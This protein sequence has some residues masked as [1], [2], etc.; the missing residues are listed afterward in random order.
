M[1]NLKTILRDA[2]EKY[3]EK[4]AIASGDFRISYEKL[5]ENSNKIAN[6]LL[7]LGVSRGDRVAILLNNSPHFVDIFFGIVKICAIAVPLD[8]KY[9]TRE[10]KSLMGHCQPKVVFTDNAY[11]EEVVS[12][13]TELNNIE[14]VIDLSADDNN[15]QS[16]SYKELRARGSAQN[17]ELDI[18]SDDIACILY[19]SGP[20]LAPK[21]VA[22]SHK[23]M[24]KAVTI[25]ADSFHQSN[26]DITIIFA[27]PMHHIVG[28][29][30]ILLTSICRGS[31]VVILPGLSITGLMQVIERERV[32]I[33]I[34]VPFIHT[35]IVKKI[36]EESKVYDLSS[37]RICGSIGA[38]LS[39][40]L[41]QQFEKFVGFRL[42]NF[43]GLTESTAHVT[44]QPLSGNGKSGSVGRV[45]PGW[46]VKIMDNNNRELPASRSGEV[47][48]RG[49][50][51][52]CYY[53]NPLDTNEIIKNGWLY[54]GDIGKMDDYGYLF[55]TG[56]KKDM[57]I[58]KG[59]NIFPSDIETILLSHPKVSDAAVT[60]IPDEMRGEVVGAIVVLKLGELITEQ[61]I[62]KFCLD[63]LAN[64]KVPKQIIFMEYLPRTN[65]GK[66]DKKAIRKHLLKMY[67]TGRGN[68][69]DES[70]NKDR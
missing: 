30:I 59:Q 22:I 61:E 32:T 27:L 69:K 21:G 60:G 13:I 46:E 25:S 62:K 9:K 66:I 11:L 40:K 2:K 15:G 17:I 56:L 35:L 43:Y 33:L 4:I 14:Y 28:L 24:V 8:T 31:T 42:I 18:E 19:T 44:R 39:H 6:G 7:Q 41:M 68:D 1:I 65:D 52:S 70:C 34:G 51:M 36:K 29:V 5:E 53:R 48:I 63:R 47:T 45:L 23:N 54:T 37:L 12:L 49:P 16:Q 38:P 67:R 58:T 20:A 3:G 57:V 50:I 26:R 10:L 64:F 55:L